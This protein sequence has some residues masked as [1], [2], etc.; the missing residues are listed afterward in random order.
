MLAI[1]S[2]HPIQ[3]QVPLWQALARDGRVP[4]QVWYVS[5]HGVRVSH[6]REF[7]QAFSWDLPLLEGYDHHFLRSAAGSRPVSFRGWR[8]SEDI[9][10]LLRASGANALWMQGWHVAAYW[11]AARMA[12]SVGVPLWMRGE[13]NDL[14]SRVAWKEA[15]KRPALGW[16]FRRVEA[17]LCIGKANRRLYERHGIGPSQLHFAPYAVD[18]ERFAQQAAELRPGRAEIRGAWGIPDDAFCILFCGKLI[19]KKHPHSLIDAAKILHRTGRIPN[20]HLLYA[21]SGELEAQLRA[22]TNGPGLPTATF[23]GFLNQREISKAYV[24]ADCL[25]LPSDHGETWGLVVNEAMAS[26]LPAVASRSAGVTE[27]LVMPTWPRRAFDCGDAVGLADALEDVHRNGPGPVEQAV[28]P[29]SFE[30]TCEEVVRLYGA[31]A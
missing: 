21:G 20:V 5:D 18:N 11:Q 8:L 25:A 6:D 3:Y 27:D 31:R 9:R 12:S 1:L 2:T 13:S 23:A 19:P 4:F 7:G 17:F 10:P 29:Y 24:A 15:I 26:G 16:L 14:K 30:R 28:T 22:A